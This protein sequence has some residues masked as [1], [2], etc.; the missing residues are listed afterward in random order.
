MTKKAVFTG[1]AALGLVLAT[2]APASAHHLHVDPHG[3]GEGTHGWVGGLPLPDAA[4]GEGL[5]PA[6]PGGVFGLQSPAHDKG[7]VV[8]CLALDSNGN[9][10]VDM[11]GPPAPGQ[12]PTC[13]HGSRPVE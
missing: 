8:A 7:L 1:A 3:S 11:F 10:V 9:S 13:R 4:S 5:I 6:G 2:A 12:E